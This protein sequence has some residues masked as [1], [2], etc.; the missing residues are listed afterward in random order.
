M[1]A[2]RIEHHS[3]L[4]YYHYSSANIATDL[5]RACFV[6]LG[7]KSERTGLNQTLVKISR[8][9]SFLAQREQGKLIITELQSNSHFSEGK[10]IEV[11]FH[12]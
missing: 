5:N 3:V 12:D 9:S 4:G 7:C 2:H 11:W 6:A 1:Y 8:V 10:T